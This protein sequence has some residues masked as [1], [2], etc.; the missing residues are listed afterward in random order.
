M[1]R[2]LLSAGWLLAW[3]ALPGCAGPTQTATRANA[4]VVILSATRTA[5][6]API[7]SASV[8]VT[9]GGEG[10]VKTRSKSPAE[11]R[12]ALPEFLVRLKRTRQA[13]VYELVTRASVREL[14]RN[15]KG[16]LKGSKRYIGAL[17]PTRIGETQVVSTDSDPIH[18]EAR[19]ERR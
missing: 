10:S 12:P 7:V 13:G 3:F 11:T 8:P 18:V 17:T 19:L 14:L 15:K 1:R 9:L 5:D 16:K 4:Y 2:F 6:H